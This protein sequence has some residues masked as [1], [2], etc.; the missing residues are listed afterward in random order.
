MPQISS[1]LEIEVFLDKQGMTFG[2][3]GT[4]VDL[5]LVLGLTNLPLHL[6]S[7]LNII[8]LAI[9]IWA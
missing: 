5:L 6:L 2:Q 1:L 7:P 8:R 3:I 4:L 9:M